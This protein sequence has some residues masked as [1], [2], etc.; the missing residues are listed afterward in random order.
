MYQQICSEGEFPK[1]WRRTMVILILKPGKYP[2]NTESYRPISLT[3]S[4]QDPRE[5]D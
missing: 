1:E 5:D 2:T 4:M 3:S